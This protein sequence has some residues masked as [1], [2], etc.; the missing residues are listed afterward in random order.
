MRILRVGSTLRLFL[1][2][3]KEPLVEFVERNQSAGLRSR[4]SHSCT[5]SVSTSSPIA[6]HGQAH[7]SINT[8]L[9]HSILHASIIFIS[10]SFLAYAFDDVYRVETWLYNSNQAINA[11]PAMT[12]LSYLDA[13]SVPVL[14]FYGPCLILS[15]LLIFRH[16]WQQSGWTWFVLTT[17]SLTRLLYAALTLAAHTHPT[18]PG[19]RAAAAT[20]AVDGL[21][22]LLLMSLGLVHRLRDFI[23]HSHP[24]AFALSGTSLLRRDCLRLVELLLAAAFICASVGYRGLS[25]DEILHG[26][27]R[28]SDTLKAAAAIVWKRKGRKYLS[29]SYGRGGFDDGNQSR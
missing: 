5:D 6:S 9:R 17:F 7:V 12:K 20:L 11:T 18:Q 23:R 22:P 1:S 28:H 29:V 8:A 25:R 16:G 4:L 21:S 14:I 24:G 27:A 10:P 26:V 13:L 2:S 3:P 15:I 19:L